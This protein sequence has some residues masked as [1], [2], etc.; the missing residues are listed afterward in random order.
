MDTVKI[1]ANIIKENMDRPEKVNKLINFGLTAAYYY[2]TFS[3]TRG[4]PNLFII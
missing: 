2:V 1:Y 4:L 3:K